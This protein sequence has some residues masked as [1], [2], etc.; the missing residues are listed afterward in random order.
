MQCTFATIRRMAKKKEGELPKENI[1]L[2]ID[3]AIIR[4]AHQ[5]AN[6]SNQSLVWWFENTLATAWGLR[7]WPKPPKG[8]KKAKEI[9][10]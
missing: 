2:R 10:P 4:K 5:L 1:T 3:P 8:L 9:K 6:E 7:S